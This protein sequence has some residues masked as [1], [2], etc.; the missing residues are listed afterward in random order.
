MAI[1]IGNAMLPQKP[2]TTNII[3]DG[4]TLPCYIVTVTKNG[5]TTPIFGNGESFLKTQGSNT[6][7]SLTRLESPNQHASLGVNPSPAFLYYGDVIQVDVTV[8]DGYKLESLYWKQGS[9]RNEIT[10][11]E[12]FTIYPT[13]TIHFYSTAVEDA[14]W[15]TVWSGSASLLVPSDYEKTLGSVVDPSYP[16]RITGSIRFD[17][18][19]DDEYYAID[20]LSI[21]VT[22]KL[23]ESPYDD[24]ETI[25]L[26]IT[27]TDDNKINVE[28]Y[29]Y[30][31][32]S[33]VHVEI[34]KIEQYY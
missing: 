12:P 8:D 30:T 29:S 2:T 22:K 31:S 20:N 19:Y 28:V 3:K 32:Y 5:V 13:D 1:E 14:S 23:F 25:T 9:T 6:S 10:S 34:T 16:T 21:P 15:K 33:S 17:Y 11:G 24:E 7:M 27:I 4:E 18:D 26:T